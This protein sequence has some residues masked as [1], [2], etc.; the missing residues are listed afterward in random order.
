MSMLSKKDIL[1][2]DDLKVEIVEV[3]EWGGSIRVSTMSA[4]ARDRFEA[5]IAKQGGGI[6]THNIRAKLAIATIVDEEN[7]PLFNE[8]DIEKLGNKSCAALDRVFAAAQRLN[9][10]TDKEVETLAKK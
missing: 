1:G 10:I 9:L 5:N 3:P 6:D 7:K 4:F 2:K 8:S